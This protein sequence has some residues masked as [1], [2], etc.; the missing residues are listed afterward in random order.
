MPQFS[1]IFNMS[2]INGTN[3]FT[4]NG[5]TA[6][7]NTGYSVASAGDVNGDG[8]DDVIVGAYTA[9]PGAGL[10]SGKS[11]VVFGKASGFATNTNLS[12]LDGTTGFVLNGTGAF[13]KSGFSVASAGDINGDGFDDIF[14]GA[15]SATAGGDV[16]AGSSFVVFGKDT[17]FSSSI[18]LSSLN[19]TTGFRIDGIDAN[20]VSGVSVASAGDVN[21]DGYDDMI[22]G[23]MMGDP[24]GVSASGESYVVFGKASGFSANFDPA[25]LDG[26]NGFRLDGVAINDYS[27]R[28]VSSAGDMNGDGF[29]D[30]VVGAFQNDAGG[31]SNAGASYVVFGKGTAFSASVALSSLDG[32]TGFRLDGIDVN[33]KAGRVV[34][35]AGDVN[36]DGFGDI[37]IGATGADSYT[38]E[39]YVVFGKATGFASTLDLSTLNGTTGFLLTGAA[40]G[41]L[42]SYSVAS[43]GDV[44]GD[45][46]DDVI[47]GAYG[48]S[49]YAGESYV[50]FGKASGFAASFN[51]SSLNGDNGFLVQGVT[52]ST[53]QSGRVASAGDVNNDGFDDIIIGSNGA[54]AFAGSSSVVFG[55]RADTAV[56]I[57]GTGVGLTHNGGLGGDVIDGK[58]GADI[59]RGWESVDRLIGG[60]GAD[61]IDGGAGNDYAS[62]ETATVGVTVDL[63]DGTGASNVG[64][65]LG[66]TFISIEKFILSSQD[67]TFYGLNSLGASNNAQGRDG[68]DTFH[69]GGLG[70]DNY[71]VGGNG[72]DTFYGSA[73]VSRATGDAGDDIYTGGGGVD[74]FLGGIGADT[75]TGAGGN[76]VAR[77]G[78]DGDTLSG[79]D[80]ADLLYGE[81]G[82]DTLNGD[83]GADTLYGGAGVDA[84]NGGANNDKIYGGTDGD[85]LNGGADLD[86]LF[87]EA[88]TDT[89]N[90]DAGNDTLDGGADA[91]S[92]NG[93]AD[94]DTLKGGLGNDRLYGGSGQDWLYGQGGADTFVF[95]NVDTGADRIYDFE[96]GVDKLEFFGLAN[97]ID[98]LTISLSAGQI[99]ILIEPSNTIFR[100]NN[101]GTAGDITALLNDMDF[102]LY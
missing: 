2:S 5:V 13:D 96:L 52:G 70:T 49:A 60:A 87:G 69:S 43:A 1:A 9:N 100:I 80:D 98:D 92:L 7:D 28:S 81:N 82:V 30:I 74:T 27:G 54:N 58:G 53:N 29:D 16:G 95:N 38:G 71:F 57:A 63:T 88:G 17:G 22:I 21:G 65:A 101:L 51:F 85:T 4:L 25:T 24:G 23:A 99:R 72:V 11:Y 42:G 48:A 33:D 3:G 40:A 78:D 12:T 79:G 46:F 61:V 6:G 84:L 67:D 45:G 83:A 55:H 68:L 18:N 20:D 26:T 47:V 76:D 10:Y 37:I 73:G 62:Y 66:D 15:L 97:G 14:I 59:L 89:L 39:S 36:G 94:S 34:A 32:T 91:D 50:V 77:G 64:D 44:N 75:F 31:D 90:G 19:G 86:S 41:G 8:F 102:L 56:V 35:S 93:G